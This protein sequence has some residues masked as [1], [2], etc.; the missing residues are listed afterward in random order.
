MHWT[1]HLEGGPRRVNH[2]AVTIGDKVFSFG[3]YCTGEDYRELRPMDVHILNTVS[4]RWFLLPLP[5]ISDP[6]RKEIPFQRYGHTA[7][8]YM[9]R[10]YIWGGRND[11]RACNKLYCFDAATLKWSNVRV[12][13]PLPSTRDGHS[14]CV[15]NHRMYIFGGYEEEEDQF[16]Q[17]VH[18]LHFPT[19]T[20]YYVSTKGTPPRWRDFHSATAVGHCMY[21]FGG[22]GDLLGP[23][24]SPNELYCNLIMCLDTVTNTWSRPRTSGAT[25]VGR[26]SHSAFYY[27]GCL[28]FFG[29]YN[30]LLTGVH[31]GDI[32]Q[33]NPVTNVW[34][35]LKIHGIGPCPRRR[36]CCCIVG[37][38][39]FIFG[40]TSPYP[41]GI[42]PIPIEYMQQGVDPTLMDHNDL[43]VLDFAPSLKTLCELA[44]IKY[45]LD[46]K[47]LPAD[48]RVEIAAMTTNNNISRPLKYASG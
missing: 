39:L 11:A 1:V 47:V 8:A 12:N 6:Q 16:S 17:D 45:Q 10:A 48:L 43:H 13:G 41:A 24:H 20:W 22:R 21:I 25:P 38:R 35:F 40:G 14:A 27:K 5:D 37:D 4:Y 31:F 7:V 29:G 3:G 46:L 36:Q 30:G 34:S 28:Y 32:Y 42:Q 33:F 19:V 26:R 2:A 18:A 9:D 23:Y 44:V 15:I